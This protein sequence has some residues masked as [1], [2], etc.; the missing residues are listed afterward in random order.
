M[1]PVAGQPDDELGFIC[2]GRA[3]DQHVYWL[4]DSERVELVRSMDLMREVALCRLAPRKRWEI[5]M[6]GHW[7]NALAGAM[8]LQHG[9]LLGEVDLS[10]RAQDHPRQCIFIGTMN[11]DADGR[12]MRDA[13]GGRRFWPVACTTINLD[14]MRT[15]R[16]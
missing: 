16:D 8:L 5:W 10:R 1:L 4:T 6:G 7:S 13:T 2:L 14:L 3:G 15:Q 12:W 11:P 9:R